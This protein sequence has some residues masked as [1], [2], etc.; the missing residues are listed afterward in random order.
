MT[1]IPYNVILHDGTEWKTVHTSDVQL[2]GLDFIRRG[3]GVAVG[4]EGKTFIFDGAGWEQRTVIP[5]VDL[6]AVSGY[7]VPGILVAVAVADS[8]AEFRYYN[9]VWSGGRSKALEWRDVMGASPSVAYGVYGDLLMR[10]DT[11]AKQWYHFLAPPTLD[12]TRVWCVGENELWALGRDGIDNYTAYYDGATW[13]THWLSSLE[14]PT[15]IWGADQHTV[16]VCADYGTVFGPAGPYSVIQPYQHLRG[17]WGIDG[18]HVWVVGENGT[19]VFFDGL[20]WTPMT[21]G[22]TVHLNAIDGSASSNILVVGD[23]GTMLRFDGGTWSPIDTGIDEDITMVSVRSSINMWAATAEGTVLRYDGDGWTTYDTGLP[24]IRH[25]AITAAAGS[26][27]WIVGDRDFV[28]R[29]AS[30]PSL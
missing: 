20:D 4:N 21:S 9:G 17:V 11:S 7:P 6:R 10:W 13:S 24:N 1:I 3:F 14:V 25:T 27:V 22:T 12:F 8:G 29:F 16:F 15:D 2:W 18:Q 19:I 30:P 5:P 28:L 23:G 26:G